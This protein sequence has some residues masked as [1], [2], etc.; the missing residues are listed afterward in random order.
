MWFL[1]F[2]ELIFHT[3]ICFTKARSHNV[4]T[5]YQTGTHLLTKC[6]LSSKT[7]NTKQYNRN[8]NKKWTRLYPFQL[9]VIVSASQGIQFESTGSHFETY[10]LNASA[11]ESNLNQISMHI[12]NGASL[13]PKTISCELTQ[14]I[15]VVRW[16]IY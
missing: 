2:F 16:K 15:F 7:E 5:S 8:T 1:S 14:R 13:G 12:T 10:Q 6:T 9:T 11:Y 3:I 4:H